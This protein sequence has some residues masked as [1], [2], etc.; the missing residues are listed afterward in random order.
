MITGLQAAHW[1]DDTFDDAV[2]FR[3][4][5]FLDS[6]G[7]FNVKNDVSLPF[8]AGRRL[9]AGETFSRNML[10][11]MSGALAQN[12][13]ISPDPTMGLPDMGQIRTGIVSHPPEF[14]AKFESR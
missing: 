9:C 14:W 3:P 5:R 12:F 2:N 4:E 7:K 13:D 8:G 11:L 6:N 10:F 1:N